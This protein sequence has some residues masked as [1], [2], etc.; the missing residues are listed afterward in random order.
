MTCAV[1]SC[2]TTACT[3]GLL[4]PG[5]NQ[6]APYLRWCAPCVCCEGPELQLCRCW[7]FCQ[8]RHWRG[9]GGGWSAPHW[10]RRLC[11]PL[12]WCWEGQWVQGH[13]SDWEQKG[14]HRPPQQSWAVWVTLVQVL[15]S[16][17][18]F[19]RM[20]FQTLNFILEDHVLPFC[21]EWLFLHSYLVPWKY[22]LSG[23]EMILTCLSLLVF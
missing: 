22:S 19:T 8:K 6:L 1:S 21:T 17:K 15:R 20:I 11:L 13:H 2:L 4:G 7:L 10:R 18:G 14:P 23:I 16:L 9:A 3:S 5:S 12:W